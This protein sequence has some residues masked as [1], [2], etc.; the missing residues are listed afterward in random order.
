MKKRLSSLLLVLCMLLSLFTFTLQSETQIPTSINAPEHFAVSPYIVDS[1]Y[2]T[3]SLPDDLRALFDAGVMSGNV[4][5]QIDYKM[6]SGDWHYMSS[7][8]SAGNTLKN[9]LLL[10][11][12]KDQSYIASTREKLSV[13]FPDDIPLLESLMNRP[14]SWEYFKS[15]EFKFRARYVVS[16]DNGSTFLYSPWSKEYILSDEVVS[17]PDQLMNHAPTLTTSTIQT[18]SGGQPF[19]HINVGRLPGDVQDMNAM[20]GGGVFT[21]IWMKRATDTDYKKINTSFFSNEFILVGVNDYFEKN[22]SSYAA[23]AYEIKIRFGID[24]RKYPQAGRTDTIYSPYSNVSSQNMPE[25][26]NVHPWA[27]TEIQNASDAG[28]IPDILKGKDLTLPINRE[29]FCEL[30]VLLYETTTGNVSTAYSPNPF[31]DTTNTQILKAYA[32]GITNGTTP[33]LFSPEALI[34]REQCAAML[35][36]TM[37]AIV[38]EGDFSTTGVAD[39]ADQKYISA[40]AV[41]AT[42]YM[43]HKGIIK[44]DNNGNFMPKGTTSS[45]KAANYGMATREQAIIMANRIYDMYNPN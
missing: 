23:E 13:F 28:L 22:K 45:Q 10:T 19:L 12:I 1:F 5:T 38:P 7:W 27:L 21:E 41:Q 34:S 37:Q 11:Y 17:N 4:R 2:Y 20:T 32:L 6:D 25:W 9:S 33:T 36:R 29:E 3:L 18:N 43:S 39:F 44:G 40:Y 26:S 30:S 24:L 15:H 42:K 14:N 31:T 8:D 35:F 16:F